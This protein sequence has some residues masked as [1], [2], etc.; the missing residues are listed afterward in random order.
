MGQRRVV[1]ESN[2]GEKKKGEERLCPVVVF[3]KRWVIENMLNL[4]ISLLRW[5]LKRTL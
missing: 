5:R 4:L 2:T 1:G 3:V